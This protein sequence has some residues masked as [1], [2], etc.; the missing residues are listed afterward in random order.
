MRNVDVTECIFIILYN[1]VLWH[2]RHKI[3]SQEAAESI[4]VRRLGTSPGISR[5]EVHTSTDSY[6]RLLYATSFAEFLS[7]RRQIGMSDWRHVGHCLCATGISLGNCNVNNSSQ[8]AAFAALA[9]W[10]I[11][12][13]LHLIRAALKFPK[14]LDL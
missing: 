3:M 8:Y 4:H 14:I 10:N 9:S 2:Y 6:S 13:K 11:S 12:I 1:R 5:L 7:L